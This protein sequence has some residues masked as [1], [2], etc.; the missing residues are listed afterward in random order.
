[1]IPEEILNDYEILEMY[2][3][4]ESGND[5]VWRGKKHSFSVMRNC[6]K[7]LK[8]LNCTDE[9]IFLGKIASLLHDIGCVD[10][11]QNH[12]E[13]SAIY[14]R[15]YLE[16]K[17]LTS[18]QIDVIVDAIKNHKDGNSINSNISA[19]LCFADKIDICKDAVR[20]M[21]TT[22]SF[23]KNMLSIDKVTLEFEEDKISV[24][25]KVDED[26]MPENVLNWDK[27]IL[28]PRK[29]ANYLDKEI[30][31]KIN[32]EEFKMYNEYKKL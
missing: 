4:I 32:D 2:N 17:D 24:N 3:K 11:R 5:D 29:I 7:I 1:M 20:N 31:F 8:S 30:C 12:E 9:E 14:A 21:D 18:N 27:A 22:D 19:A 15:K 25:Y 10:G 26:F 23:V 28:I 13:K 6:E 16:N